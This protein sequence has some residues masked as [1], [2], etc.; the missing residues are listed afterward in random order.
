MNLDEQKLP[1]NKN[2][3]IFFSII[4]G[5]LSLFLYY[6]EAVSLSALF[7]ILAAIFILV[8]FIKSELL[9]PFNKMWI[10]LGI[11]LSKIV[12]PIVLG[13]VFF[14]IFTPLA[15]IMRISNRD[16]LLL[17]LKDKKSHWKI[18]APNEPDAESFKN[19]F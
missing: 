9:F 17:K 7:G 18:R 19:Q 14:F 15:M 6:K 10:N 2:F 5:S 1:S 12:S 16:E 3:G 11:F 4:F 13:T 8:S